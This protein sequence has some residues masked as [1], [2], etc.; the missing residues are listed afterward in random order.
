MTSDVV[1]QQLTKNEVTK[2][3]GSQSE[4]TYIYISLFTYLYLYT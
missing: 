1:R 4:V 3:K 2:V